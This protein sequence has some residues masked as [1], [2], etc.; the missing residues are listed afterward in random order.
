MIAYALVLFVLWWYWRLL[1]HINDTTGFFF[2]IVHF[3]PAAITLQ[4][5]LGIITI[6]NCVGSI[7]LLWGVLHQAGAIMLLAVMLKVQYFSF[8]RNF[9]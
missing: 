9:T 1:E 6:I 2:R 7:P 8:P 4:V 5:L 3:L